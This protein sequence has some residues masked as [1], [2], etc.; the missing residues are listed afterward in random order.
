MPLAFI[1]AAQVIISI[2]MF[3]V[4]PDKT[5]ACSSA[6]LGLTPYPPTSAAYP[7]LL[8]ALAASTQAIASPVWPTTISLIKT[9][10]Y[11][12]APISTSAKL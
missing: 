4:P 7:V 6:P 3:P 5:P 1:P 8:P 12:C 10:A 11:R 2:R 9:P